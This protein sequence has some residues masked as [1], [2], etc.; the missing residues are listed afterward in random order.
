MIIGC[1]YSLVHLFMYVSNQ[2]GLTQESLKSAT[3][4]NTDHQDEIPVPRKWISATSDLVHA[5]LVIRYRQIW[6]VV[7]LKDLF[8]LKILKTCPN[9]V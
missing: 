1:L 2:D 7:H 9:L 8:S 5:G 3:G 6:H 4:A